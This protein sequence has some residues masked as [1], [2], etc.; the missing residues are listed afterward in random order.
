MSDTNRT[1]AQNP[2]SPA[3]LRR[4]AVLALIGVSKA[5]PVPMGE[6]RDVPAVPRTDTHPRHRG[7]V[8]RRG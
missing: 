8:S 4:P 2:T 5:T 3:L 6:R 7:M 1:T